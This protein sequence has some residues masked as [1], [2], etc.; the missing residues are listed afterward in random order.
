MYEWI[1]VR[2][3]ASF[4]EKGVY[5]LLEFLRYHFPTIFYILLVVFI[6]PSLQ[7]LMFTY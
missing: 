4:P 5:E 7:Y 6:K 1:R 2:K 3:L